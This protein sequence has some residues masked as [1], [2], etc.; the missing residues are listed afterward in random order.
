ML[1]PWLQ[2]PNVLQIAQA[3]SQTGLGLRH[4][5]LAEAEEAQQAQNAANLLNYHYTQL[6]ASQQ[7]Q[8]AQLAQTA[9]ATAAAR[10]LAQQREQA[11][12]THQRAQ[13]EHLQAT[14]KQAAENAAMQ[15]QHNNALEAH[16]LALE[17]AAQE[18]ASAPMPDLVVKDIP[19]FGTVLF[20]PKTGG[21]H[22]QPK[23]AEALARRKADYQELIRRRRETEKTLKE[24]PA[25]GSERQPLLDAYTTANQA[26][27][28][29]WNAPAA[30]PTPTNAPAASSPSTNTPALVLPAGRKQLTKEQGVAFLRQA[31]GDKEKA[32]ALAREQGYDL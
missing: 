17:Q 7:E 9:Q 10:A 16:Q 19:N 13:E 25:L 8:Q 2:A 11:L 28:N 26:V 22:S 29:Y 3:G 12:E 27:L 5:Q 21:I 1:A 32:R 24:A 31:R 6:Q 18:K 30:T 23:D 4:Q 14:E 15:L 20:N